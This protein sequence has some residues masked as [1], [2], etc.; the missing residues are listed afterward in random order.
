GWQI[1][2]CF[3]LTHT[4]SR[5]SPARDGDPDLPPE[6]RDF[7]PR[8]FSRSR[9]ACRAPP[10]APQNDADRFFY[11]KIEGLAVSFR[12]AFDLADGSFRSEAAA[13]ARERVQAVFL[14]FAGD[15]IARKAIPSLAPV[16]QRIAVPGLLDA[17]R[18]QVQF[19][20]NFQRP[21]HE[22]ALR[23][24]QWRHGMF[25]RRVND[26]GGFQVLRA[27]LGG[28]ADGAVRLDV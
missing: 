12:R 15:S 23:Q 9:G 19:L 17:Q 5:A 14:P 26:H 21:F 10:S 2:R 22:L 6:T 3:A 20:P 1:G 7:L 13:A 11:R 28:V 18:R 27:G 8:E 4:A 25:Q 16:S 24:S